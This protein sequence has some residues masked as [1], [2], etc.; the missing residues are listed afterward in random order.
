MKQV[1]YIFSDLLSKLRALKGKTV[2]FIIAIS[3]LLI[4]P[5]LLALGYVIYQE[6]AKPVEY[7]SVTLYDI[8][9]K[10]IAEESQTLDDTGSSSLLKIFYHLVSDEK[11]RIEKLEVSESEAF[12]RADIDYN[13]TKFNINCYFSTD[14]EKRGY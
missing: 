6:I 1:K 2:A 3:V 7:F 13:G 11:N 9:D 14:P 5:T 12:V 4:A 8:E 10:V